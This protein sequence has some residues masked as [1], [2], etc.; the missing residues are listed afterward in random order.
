MFSQKV[1]HFVSDIAILYDNWATSR[2]NV[3]SGIFDQ[4][5]QLRKLARILK[6]RL[7]QVYISYYLSSEQQRCWADC[8]DAQ[9]DLRF[10]CSHMAYDT[11]SYDLVHIY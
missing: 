9:A 11:F 1:K 2:E 7:Q 8:A 3:S 4:L 5:A 6:L 10:C